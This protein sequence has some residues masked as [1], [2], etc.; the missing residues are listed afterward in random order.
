MDVYASHISRTIMSASSHLMGLF[1]LGL[2]DNIT[3]DLSSR[4][5]LPPIKDINIEY[6]NIS[7]LP[8][9]FKPFP[10]AI[11]NPELDILFF[12]NFGV[13]PDAN[14]ALN[15][16]YINL[17]KKY[18]N[19]T[20]NISDRLIAKGWNPKELYNQDNFTVDKIA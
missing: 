17:V 3:V 2:G 4:H 9:S 11:R 5:I 6:R 14:T 13:C 15:V 18:S 7:A 20:L 16:K 10:V 19:L 1:P 12:P 8:Y